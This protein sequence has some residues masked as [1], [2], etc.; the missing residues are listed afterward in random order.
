[1]A[2]FRFH[3]VC[4]EWSFLDDSGQTFR[5]DTE[6][7]EH[8]ATITRE[9]AADGSAYHDCAILVVDEDDRELAL[10]PI[11]KLES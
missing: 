10:L 8:A 11:R 9:L 2:R 7:F 6:A 1:M 5:S 4:S 3:I